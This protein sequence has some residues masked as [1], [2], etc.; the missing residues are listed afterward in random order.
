MKLPDTLP[1]EA[2][3]KLHDAADRIGERVAMGTLLEVTTTQPVNMKAAGKV[4]YSVET[5]AAVCICKR[6]SE[7]KT[8]GVMFFWNE[9]NVECTYT[10]LQPLPMSHVIHLT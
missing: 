10:H 2:Q 4:L 5:V 8:P 6:Y 9:P 7:E 1:R 3:S